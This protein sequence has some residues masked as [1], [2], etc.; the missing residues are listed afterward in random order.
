M[1]PHVG[2]YGISMTAQ[3]RSGQARLETVTKVTLAVLALASGVYTYL[4]VRGLLNGTATVVFFGA[5][6]YSAAVSVGIYAFWSYLMRF[7]PHVESARSRF[8]LYVAMAIGSA[9]II[10]MSSWLNAAALAG[11]AALEQHMA[12]ATEI[13]QEQLD[14]AHANALA[15]QSLLPDIQLAS[16]R[17]ANLS[18]QERA[19]GALTGT[20][21]S[22][23]VAQLLTQMSTELDR[24]AQEVEESRDAVKGHFEQGGRHLAR[25]RELVSGST[26]IEAR[27]NAFGEEALKLIG[28]ITALEQTSVAPSV[29]RAAEDLSKTFIAPVADGQDANLQQRQT[30]MVGRVEKAVAAQSRALA[31]AADEI[32]N[33]DKAVPPRF[34]PLS[35]PEAVL[36]YAGDFLP[37]WAGAISIDLLPAVLIFILVIVEGSIRRQGGSEFDAETMSAAEVMRAVAIYRQ[38]HGEPVPATA[39]AAPEREQRPGPPAETAPPAGGTGPENVARL[40]PTRRTE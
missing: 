1:Q 38:M 16:K 33:R 9:M 17:F 27:A 11:S 4:G 30:T 19:S 18:E 15:A 22:G 25:M 5:I 12:H 21:G 35:P 10:A 32:L 6:I 20:S 14:K 31:A 29:K 8:W 40:T 7:L 23:T 3:L 13:N 39:E 24:L 26:Q 37:S 2:Q 36:D 34:Q 28:Q